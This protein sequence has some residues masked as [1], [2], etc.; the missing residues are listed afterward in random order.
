ELAIALGQ[1]ERLRIDRAASGG[2]G[3]GP[4]GGDHV[5]LPI[6]QVFHLPTRW[7][8]GAEGA[9]GGVRLSIS[10]VNRPTLGRQRGLHQRFGKR[11]MRVDR[12][13]DLLECQ[14]VLDGK[15][16]LGDQVRRSRSDDVR[17]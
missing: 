4:D 10:D 15:R 5:L 7:G 1:L 12:E 13:V 9:G 2:W 11:R 17:A 14:A 3:G 6:L 16:R 8:G